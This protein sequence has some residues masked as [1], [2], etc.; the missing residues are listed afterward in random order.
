M[1][2]HHSVERTDRKANQLPQKLSKVFSACW[3]VSVEAHG[4]G[5]C[6]IHVIPHQPIMLV[7]GV[8]QLVLC[9]IITGV[10]SHTAHQAVG[11]VAAG[12]ADAGDRGVL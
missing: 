2:G 4:G 3:L 9:N 11:S 5:E 8:H 6:R 1:L 10:V 12:G 7:C